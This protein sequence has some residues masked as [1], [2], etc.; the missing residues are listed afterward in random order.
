MKPNSISAVSLLD[1]VQVHQFT[2]GSY[3]SVKHIYEH[4]LIC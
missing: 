1:Q 3:S 4:S 2:Y